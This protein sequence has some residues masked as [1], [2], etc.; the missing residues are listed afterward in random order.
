MVAVDEENR[1][2]RFTL[3]NGDSTVGV[4]DLAANF[5]GI[6]G[7]RELP[8]IRMLSISMTVLAMRAVSA[9]N[10]LEGGARNKNVLRLHARSI[11]TLEIQGS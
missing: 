10:S 3:T 5:G 6:L 8:R 9:R 2:V 11:P 1:L 7:G 4:E